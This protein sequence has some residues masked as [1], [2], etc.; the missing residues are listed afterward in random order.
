M[1]Y[2]NTDV[3]VITTND[4]SSVSPGD[5]LVFYRTDGIIFLSTK[6][7]VPKLFSGACTEDY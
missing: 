3:I 2:F 4:F 7:I 6:M 1:T 5:V